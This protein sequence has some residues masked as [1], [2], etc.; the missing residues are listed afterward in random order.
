MKMLNAE[1]C[2]PSQSSVHGPALAPGPD[3][4]RF[5]LLLLLPSVARLLRPSV[6]L[7]L[8]LWLPLLLAAGLRLLSVYPA[9]LLSPALLSRLLLPS[10]ARLLRPSVALP[11]VALLLPSASLLWL[12]SVALP[13]L[14]AAGLRLLSVYPALS[15]RL[16]L[17]LPSASRLWLPPSVALLLCE[18]KRWRLTLCDAYT[19]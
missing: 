6:S 17:L 19:A 4:L 14:L 5:P 1:H 12:P 8:L 11:S 7:L 16:W 9:L 10:V 3:D 15:S 2:L 18:L 13:L